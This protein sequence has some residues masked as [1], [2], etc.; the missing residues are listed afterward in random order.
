M[1]GNLFLRLSVERLLR[2][3]PDRLLVAVGVCD[4]LVLLH[5]EAS[6]ALVALG[7]RPIS[8]VSCLSIT[9]TAKSMPVDVLG[10]E[11]WRARYVDHVGGGVLHPELARDGLEV[12][13]NHRP[14]CSLCRRPIDARPC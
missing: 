8:G 13:L 5:A 10:G 14:H 11:F 7:E 6:L 1:M 3:V 9:P 12:F 4:G 2:R